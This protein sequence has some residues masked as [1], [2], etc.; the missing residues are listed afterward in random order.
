MKNKV[1]QQF[2]IKSIRTKILLGF[3]MVI[4]LTVG[5]GTYNFISSQSIN[6]HAKDMITHQI[7]LLIAD[8]TLGQN[9]A[10]RI[11]SARGFVLTG[12]Q[13]YIDQFN[14]SSDKSRKVEETA[15]QISD[16]EDFKQ[17]VARSVEWEQRVREEVFAVYE[18]GNEAVAQDNLE[19]PLRIEAQEI[20]SGYRYLI[21]NREKL[22]DRAGEN[23]LKNNDSNMV[24]GI[25]IS[26]VVAVLGIAIA[27]M[28][29]T[30]ISKPIQT[31]TYRM[32][33]LAEG[34]LSQE[35]LVTKSGDEIGRLFTAT[36]KMNENIK[37]LVSEIR[38]VSGTVS[39]QSEELTQAATEVKEGSSQVAITMQDL[40]SGAEVQ[41]DTASELSSSM[42]E[43][44]DK[45]NDASKTG[46]E[47]YHSSQTVIRMTEK[48]SELMTSSI[49]QMATIHS[50]V[51]DAT[52]KVKLLDKQSEEISKLVGVIQSIAEQTNLLALNAA[53]EAARAGEHGRGFSVV[54]SEVRKLAEQVSFSVADITEIVGKIQ[55]DSNLVAKSLQTGYQEVEN[56]TEQIKTTGEMFEKI[57]QA[58]LEMTRGVQVIS[59]SL[60]TI[61]NSSDEINKSIEDI[62]AVSE[63]SAAGIQQTAASVQ[64]TS[65]SMEG[66][67][68]NA[69][70]L[71]KLA[72]NLNQQVGR[73]KM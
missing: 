9:M 22:I 61:E 32:G 17:L 69:A 20:M 48:G 1:F 53:I 3:S 42:Q 68:G 51:E 46:K 29:S 37:G 7:P 30:I 10:D 40:S 43:F 55:S 56:G 63:Q 58:L 70:Q 14:T 6:S 16:S 15:L 19:G 8:E 18:S 27:I 52:N 49:Q 5:F 21:N 28:M 71:N 57:N 35:P 12:K 34:D 11:G 31:V 2:K 73:F 24:V 50:I 33:I 25:T 41:A 64:Q 36:N 26:G 59:E 4:L 67:A 62:A 47:V 44:A 66:V 54:A 38:T 13:E 23:L 65:S 60:S 39:A 45:I 72:E